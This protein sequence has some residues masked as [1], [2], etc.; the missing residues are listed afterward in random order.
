MSTQ[1]QRHRHSGGTWGQGPGVQ[2]CEHELQMNVAPKGQ[3]TARWPGQQVARLPNKSWCQPSLTYSGK[4]FIGGMS[5]AWNSP[6]KNMGVGSWFLLQG[7]FLT[8][9]SKPSLLHWQAGSLPLS[10]TGKPKLI[11]DTLTMQMWFLRM[12]GRGPGVHYLQSNHFCWEVQDLRIQLNNWRNGS[13]AK[14]V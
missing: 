1:F 11:C 8:Q 4:S 9:G 14:Y 13:T 3:N 6:G 7:I 12:D 2:A 5:H 10:H